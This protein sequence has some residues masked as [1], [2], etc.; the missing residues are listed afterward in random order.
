MRN[1]EAEKMIADL[2]AKLQEKTSTIEALGKEKSKLAQTIQQK[3][4]EIR[5][6]KLKKD[7]VSHQSINQPKNTPQSDSETPLSENARTKNPGIAIKNLKIV[8][9]NHPTLPTDEV[10]ASSLTGEYL[11]VPQAFK[12]YLFLK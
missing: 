3:E 4:D 1:E 7:H 8:L 6:I 12:V 5:L 11:K 2:E 9:N 10:C